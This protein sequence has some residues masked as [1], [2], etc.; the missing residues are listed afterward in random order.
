MTE[1]KKAY[2]ADK[3]AALQEEN[4][5]LRGNLKMLCC[6]LTELKHFI[7]VLNYAQQKL[8]DTLD[9]GDTA[10]SC[11]GYSIGNSFIGRNSFV[12]DSKYQSFMQVQ[13]EIE[14][15]EIA[16]HLLQDYITNN[17]KSNMED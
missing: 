17:F 7:T 1:E 4:K 6:Q 16:M 8:L 13:S 10:G 12:I 11:P 9:L 5:Y 3:L 2:E 15:A 14:D